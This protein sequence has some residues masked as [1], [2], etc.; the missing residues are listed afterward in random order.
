MFFL[1]LI[2]TIATA[3]ALFYYFLPVLKARKLFE[4]HSLSNEAAG[5]DDVQA[6]RLELRMVNDKVEELEMHLGNIKH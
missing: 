1:I 6:L 3:F 5:A 4:Y 2:F